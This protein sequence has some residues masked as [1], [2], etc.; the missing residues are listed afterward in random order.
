MRRILIAAAALVFTAPPQAEDAPWTLPSSEDIRQVL[1][2]RMEHNGVGTVV[3]VID[4]QGPRVVA[5]G[6]S[7]AADG[8]PL[9]GDTIFQIGSITKVFTSL[10]LAEMVQR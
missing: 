4:A 2:T 8:R 7:G 5:Y 10:L 3:G 6:K 9:D 1:A